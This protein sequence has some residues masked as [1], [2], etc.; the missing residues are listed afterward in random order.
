[1]FDFNGILTKPPLKLKGM[2]MYYFPL[3]Y[4]DAITYPC[5]NPDAGL[6]NIRD[7][8]DIESIVLWVCVYTV[9]SLI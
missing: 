4:A 7:I 5:P 8:Y 3:F 6:G 9:K 1:M 2:D